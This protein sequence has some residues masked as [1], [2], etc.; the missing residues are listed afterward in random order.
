MHFLV[1]LVLP[2]LHGER[3]YLKIQNK[4]ITKQANFAS[5]RWLYFN[6]FPPQLW[7][8][9]SNERN[10]FHDSYL[11]AA[12]PCSIEDCLHP[13][14]AYLILRIW[15]MTCRWCIFHYSQDQFSSTLQPIWNSGAFV[16]IQNEVSPGDEIECVLNSSPL[17][18]KLDMQDS[19]L[20]WALDTRSTGNCTPDRIFE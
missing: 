9:L 3:H 7:S 6:P 15:I 20:Y 17:C 5:G 12:Q 13:E 8:C 4:V 1:P 14:L 2:F 16:F 18:Q 10:G 19:R 11:V